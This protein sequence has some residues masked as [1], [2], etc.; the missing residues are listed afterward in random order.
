MCSPKRKYKFEK[1]EQTIKFNRSAA[2]KIKTVALFY[3]IT[4]VWSSTFF[5]DRLLCFGHIQSKNEVTPLEVSIKFGQDGG[6]KN[7]G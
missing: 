5:L 4:A 6:V 7:F 3:L 1:S 2:E